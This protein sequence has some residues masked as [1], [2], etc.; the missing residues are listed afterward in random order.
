M[1]PLTAKCSALVFWISLLPL[2]PLVTSSYFIV[3]LVSFAYA[4]FLS[5]GSTHSVV[6]HICRCHYTSSFFLIPSH[7]WCPTRL[8]LDPILF[9][10]YNTPLSY[11]I[12]SST[13]SHLLYADDTQLSISFHPKNFLLA[14]L[15][16]QSTVSLIS[17]WI[18][19][20]YLIL[21]LTKT[22][23]LLIGLHQ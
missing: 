8:F 21:N 14:I 23:F 3:F 9:N 1:L 7:S 10:L 2:I 4:L 18:S 11:Q 17:S 22:A 12:S 20:N 15:A 6:L 5:S 16:L 19:S 13:I